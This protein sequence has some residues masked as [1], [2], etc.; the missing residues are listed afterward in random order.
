LGR[1]KISRK[2]EVKIINSQTSDFKKGFLHK[3]IRQ[4]NSAVAKTTIANIAAQT[5]SSADEKAP[6][7]AIK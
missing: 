2:S 4:T 3:I 5:A 7:K 1:R 6:A